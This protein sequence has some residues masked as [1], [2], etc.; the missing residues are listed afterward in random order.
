MLTY[1]ATTHVLIKVTIFFLVWTCAWLPLGIT[2]AKI[3]NWQPPQPLSNEQK[4][5]LLASLYLIA[6][7]I[8]WGFMEVENSSWLDYGLVWRF[9]LLKS[10]G[11]GL[12][13]GI[14]GI[15]IIFG[16]KLALGWVVWNGE[17]LARLWSVYLPILGLGL[18]V[19]ITEE[20]VFRGLLINELTE[21]YPLWLGA[22]ISS[23][24][25][26]LLHLLW[27]RQKT[28]PQ[29]PG[30]WLMGMVLVLARWVDHSNL[31]LAWGLH[32]GWIWGL[33][34]LDAAQLISYTD[35]GLNWIIGIGKQ[36]LA[37]LAGILCL[38][39]TGG[40]LLLTVRI[41]AI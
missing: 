30:L 9:T 6:P 34:C 8:V 10:L 4:L 22:T 7:L 15:A 11:W 20:L 2:V 28:I 41:F 16:L 26:A 32:A 29:L 17:N 1:L 21:N 27:E 24:I 39:G 38:L 37:G 25:F 13:L 36:P 5:P 14:T 3:V 12:I 40:F 31:G 18:W 35:K 33:S 19:G 23:I